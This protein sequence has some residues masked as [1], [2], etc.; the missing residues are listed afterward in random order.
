MIKVRLVAGISNDSINKYCDVCECFNYTRCYG[1][2]ASIKYIKKGFNIIVGD[3]KFI[4][5]APRIE[6]INALKSLPIE[7]ECIIVA[8]PLEALDYSDTSDAIIKQYQAP[9]YE[10]GFTNIGIF[11]PDDTDKLYGHWS[12]W[13]KSVM[14]YNQYS[15]HHRYTL[16][17]HCLR[18]KLGCEAYNGAF[19][20]ELII[21]SALHDVG[22]PYTQTFDEH[23]EAHYHY[24]TN[25][26]AYNCLFY[27]CDNADKLIISQ[28]ISNHTDPRRVQKLPDNSTVYNLVKYLY[29]IDRSD[30]D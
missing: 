3:I 17:E 15:S 14:D 7:F 19:R 24:H 9:L 30:D 29:E 27:D 5:S 4:A 22:K 13:I 11:Y 23:R 26:G 21:A 10:E 6:F 1:V 12:D 8:T 25:I 18:C 16:G 28:I 20:N 2:N